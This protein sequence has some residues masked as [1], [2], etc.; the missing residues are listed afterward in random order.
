VKKKNNIIF[1]SI[2]FQFSGADVNRSTNSN[3][4]TVLSLACAGGHLEV[5]SLLLKHGSDPNHLLKVN[6]TFFKFCKNDF[7]FFY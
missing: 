3:D 4:S 2:I 6:T 1:K 5:A 7:L